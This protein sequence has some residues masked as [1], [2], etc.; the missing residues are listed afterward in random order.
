MKLY[1][2][3]E[4][5]RT[6]NHPALESNLLQAFDR[7]PENWEPFVR[8]ERPSVGPYE[9]LESE[10]PTYQKIDDVWTDVWTINTMTEEEKI[11]KQQAVIATFNDREQS[12]NWSAWTL[13]ETT[14]TMVPPIPQPDP[15]ETKLEQ[16]IYTF[17][18]GAENNWKDTPVYPGNNYKFDFFAWQWT[19]VT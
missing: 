16:G 13:D 19:E 17:W 11:A 8:N 14:C 18:C 4:N 12:E 15:D 9:I 5:G 10:M 6:I 1:I 7:I 3:V 2:Q